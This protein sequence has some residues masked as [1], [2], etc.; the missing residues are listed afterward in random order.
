MN[1]VL[2]NS[3]SLAYIL[4]FVSAVTPYE[5]AINKIVQKFQLYSS[6]VPS[7]EA[8]DELHN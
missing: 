3:Y 4:H 8:V 5:I 1:S 7:T 6:G 2:T